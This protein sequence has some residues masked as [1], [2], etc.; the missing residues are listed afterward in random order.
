MKYS[1][2]IRPEAETELKD[3]FLWYEKQ[4]RGLGFEFIRCVDAALT[5]INRSPL[6]YAEVHNNI[7]RVLVRKFPFEIFYITD[8]NKIVVL[9]VFHA[10]RNPAHWQERR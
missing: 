9:A 2:I 1:V 10:K 4:N 3:A 7:R 8:E 5:L 6:I